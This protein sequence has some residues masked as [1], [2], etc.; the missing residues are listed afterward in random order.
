MMIRF[1]PHKQRMRLLH[2]LLSIVLMGAFLCLPMGAVAASDGPQEQEFVVTAYY[3]PLPDQCCYVKG[4]LEA[5]QMLNGNGTNAADGTPVYAG[6]IAAPSSYAFGTHIV[7]PGLGVFTVHDRGGAIN[8][9]DDAH[10]IDI[11]VGSGEEG[12]ARALAFGVQHVRGTVYMPAAI[13]PNDLFVLERLPAPADVLSPYLVQGNEFPSVYPTLGQKGL[14]VRSL[15]KQLQ[16]AGYFD[17][18]ITGYFGPATQRSVRALIAEYVLNEPDDRWTPMSAAYAEAV[19]LVKSRAQSVPVP[20]VNADSSA[21]DLAQAQRLL[22]SL[23]YYRGR[24]NGQYS[25]TLR[26][27]ILAYQQQQRLVVGDTSPGAGRIG[28]LTRQHLTSAWQRK[29]VIAIAQTMLD[30]ERIRLAL[31]ERGALI[32]QFLSEGSFGDSVRKV[33]ELL[34]DRGYFPREM[35]NGSFG[36]LTKKSVLQYQL[37][38]GIIGSA[39]DT[40]AGMIGP[41]TAAALTAEQV[42]VMYRM[43]Q[44]EGWE[45]L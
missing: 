27:A 36:P 37:N 19:I 9:W 23:G 43:V 26:S 10:R 21:R 42:A 16:A 1:I 20:F 13:V 34:A 3:S 38:R 14:A 5:D 12:L 15:Q 40:G 32:E 17:E 29:R 33:Q 6:M 7:L 22:R 4:S 18:E 39:Q 24:T 44:G 30:R 31:A 28:P 45:V 8:E 2:R 41:K 25:A 35:I 11:W